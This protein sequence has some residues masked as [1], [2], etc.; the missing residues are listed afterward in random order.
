MDRRAT[1]QCNMCPYICLCSLLAATSQFRVY[2]DSIGQKIQLT[3]WE[4]A[5][6]MHNATCADTPWHKRQLR[7]PTVHSYTMLGSSSGLMKLCNKFTWC[8]HKAIKLDWLQYSL[9]KRT[10]NLYPNSYGQ[11]SILAGGVSDIKLYIRTY[12]VYTTFIIL[13]GIGSLPLIP[14]DL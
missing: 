1:Q 5:N 14:W 13:P 12:I 6:N 7:G 4:N 2:I 8:F 11:I 9:C 10:R 3:G